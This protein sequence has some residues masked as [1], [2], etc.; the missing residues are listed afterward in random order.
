MPH[1]RAEP[2][3]VALADP[4]HQG[5]ADRSAVA[6]LHVQLDQPVGTRGV[7]GGVVAPQP[8]AQVGLQRDRLSGVVVVLRPGPDP[9]H[10]DVDV[11]P[12]VRHDVGVPPGRLLRRLVGRRDHDLGDQRVGL[13]P[14]L[15]QL[16][17]PLVV[18]VLEGG[19]QAG[20]DRRVVR[21]EGAELPVVAAELLQDRHERVEVVDP[22]DDVAQRGEEPVALV[23]HRDG[24]HRP[25]LGM[26]QEQVGVEVQR[27]LVPGRG[28]L[29]EVGPHRRNV[30]ER[31]LGSGRPGAPWRARTDDGWGA[32]LSPPR[33]ARGGPRRACPRSRSRPARDR[34]RTPRTGC[35]APARRA[36]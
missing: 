9:E 27:G 3:D 7:G 32:A 31:L 6:G 28:R 20:A 1:R 15:G 33:T 34:D 4:A 36:G 26:A 13:G 18:E 12:V 17:G 35:P 21:R 16:R 2:Q 22:R 25:G 14:L 19:Q 5:R 11:P 29:G 10:G 23:R 8:R 30:H 24:E